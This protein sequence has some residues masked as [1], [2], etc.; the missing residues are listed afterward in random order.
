M[1]IAL[2]I[3]FVGIFLLA[4]AANYLVPM[5]SPWMRML[6]L[7]TWPLV[8]CGLLFLLAYIYV[9]FPNPAR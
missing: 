8:L 5:G 6:L 4:I 7:L 1:S 2:D 3:Y 9:R